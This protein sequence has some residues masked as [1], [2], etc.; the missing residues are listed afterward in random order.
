M[1]DLWTA[2]GLLYTGELVF[3]FSVAEEI[4]RLV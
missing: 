4:W 2:S 3:R 1:S